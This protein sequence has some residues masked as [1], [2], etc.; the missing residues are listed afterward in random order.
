MHHQIL[1]VSFREI[2]GHRFPDT[3]GNL[4]H[5]PATLSSL[6]LWTCAVLAKCRPTRDP[7][8]LPNPILIFRSLTKQSIRATVYPLLAVLFCCLVVWLVLF[9]VVI[10]PFLIRPS[11]KP[12]DRHLDR[13]E[14]Q[15]NNKQTN[16]EDTQIAY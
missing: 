14:K 10:P 12:K 1:L 13:F 2:P 7:D 3:P 11:I 4:P 5:I 16:K 8:L 15:Q 6:F 9:V